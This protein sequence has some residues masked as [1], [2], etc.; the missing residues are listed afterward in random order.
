M[1]RGNK[2]GNSCVVNKGRYKMEGKLASVPHNTVPN[3]NNFFT[4]ANLVASFIKII[5]ML[6]V[7]WIS[8]SILCK[9]K[10]C[11]GC[12]F[13]MQSAID[14]VLSIYKNCSINIFFIF[15]LNKNIFKLFKLFIYNRCA[16][17]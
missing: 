14:S 6:E 4:F 3:D 8:K 7:I 17:Y 16:F 13:L 12:F 2:D 9:T 10:I 15:I 1:S 5:W 11:V